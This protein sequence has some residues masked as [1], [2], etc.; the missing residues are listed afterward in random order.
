MNVDVRKPGPKDRERGRLLS[1]R[2]KSLGL[3]QAVV[4]A[5]IGVSTQQYGEYERGE[6]RMSVERYE[7]ICAGLDAMEAGRG[8]Q[9][10][11]AAAFE[12]PVSKAALQRGIDQMRVTLDMWQRYLDRM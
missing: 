12:A 2:R 1:R 4:A 9:E 6:N 11:P 3:S 5:G 8:F 7:A 10:A